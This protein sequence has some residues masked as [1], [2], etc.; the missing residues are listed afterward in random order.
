MLCMGGCVYSYVKHTIE[1]GK[2]PILLGS[3]EPDTSIGSFADAPC[4]RLVQAGDASIR[5][6]AHPLSAGAN[7]HGA[8]LPLLPEKLE[9]RYSAMSGVRL[10]SRS[11][12]T[13]HASRRVD[14]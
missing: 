6:D 13:R 12:K 9:Y 8:T 5:P 14:P 7:P 2:K 4:A 1:E 10:Q 11:D 3:G